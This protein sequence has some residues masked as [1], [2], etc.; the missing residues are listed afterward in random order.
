MISFALHGGSVKHGGDELSGNPEPFL[1]EFCLTP[2]LTLADSGGLEFIGDTQE[3]HML[4]LT[5]IYLRFT[6][7]PTNEGSQLGSRGYFPQ[8]CSGNYDK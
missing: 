1:N 7:Y 8:K 6:C 2:Q 3:H 5:S 4:L